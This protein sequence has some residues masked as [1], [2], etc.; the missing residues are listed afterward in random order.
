MS[1]IKKLNEIIYKY[2]A[3]LICYDSGTSQSALGN[4][5]TFSNSYTARNIGGIDCITY[6]Y[7][8]IGLEN[9]VYF[10]GN[11][12]A[13]KEVFVDEKSIGYNMGYVVDVLCCEL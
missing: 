3:E 5:V 8:T 10:L 12:I 9:C 7:Y 11:R 2:D 13:D 4:G 1:Q 6:L